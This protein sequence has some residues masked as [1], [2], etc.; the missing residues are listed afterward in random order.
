MCGIIGFVGEE[1]AAPIILSS[2][3]NLEYR[4]YDSAGIATISDGKICLKKD[5]GHLEEVQ[6]KH[7]LDELPG[8]LGIGHV[9]WATH[10]GV[11]ANNA[12]PH[13]DCSGNIAVVHNGIIENY[14]E[15]RSRLKSKH[16]FISQ[17]DTE[18]IPH[19]LEDY[20]NDGASLE[21]G[22]IRVTKQ[23]QGSY[24]FV[25]IYSREPGKIVA[26]RQGNSL[27]VGLADGRKFI[28]SDSLSFLKMTDQAIFVEDGEI[29]VAT[30]DKVRFFNQD[31]LEL[32]KS[33]GKIDWKWDEATKQGYDSFTLKE[34]LEEPET[35]RR[36]LMQDKNLVMDMALGILR[37]RQ[38]V[39][40]GCGTSRYAALLGRYVFSK[41]G[42]GFSPVI[43][44]SEYPY[45]SESI[46]SST[47]VMAVS[48][49]G[50]TADILEAVR[51]AK[52]KS[53]TIFSI[54]NR[55][56]SSL[57]RMSNKVLYLNC[58]PEIGVVA[59]KSFVAQLIIFYLLGF[60]IGN[61][62]DEGLD[63]LAAAPS[64]IA[65]NHREN[66]KGL[67]KLAWKLR[68]RKDFYYIA[69]GTNFH[70]AGEAALKLKEIAY[71][72]A[73]G[74]PAGELK[75]GSLALIEKGTPVIAICPEDYTFHE[76]LSNVEEA[77]ARGAFVIGVS[78]RREDVFDEWIKIPKVEEI[79]YPLVSIVPLQLF[80]Y[81]SAIARA[82][83]PDKPRN[84][85]KSVT[86][87]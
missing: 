3:E 17:T 50:E 4:G 67:I 70:I 47:L 1:Q 2:L 44:A 31:S 37:A 46:D 25:A 53:A 27:I 8:V 16:N 74:M 72:H 75:H 42:G 6:Q 19:L 56:D 34:I 48:Q 73:D 43:I 21:E 76:T 38:V 59:T 11:T 10:G 78:D 60:A 79:F 58:G 15:L 87:K 80:A 40:I 54:V 26:A 52:R 84:L 12:H 36:A 68:K 77:K 66:G 23:L 45:F 83:D 63:K 30:K 39:F 81:H 71:V 20:L 33:P 13:L 28:A 65:G 41:F 32:E 61:K 22:V 64:W 86:V 69:R 9:R 62:L 5:V 51:A 35:A 18:V 57:A 7:H 85:A 49:S 82:L 29:V 14:R 55:V 24:A